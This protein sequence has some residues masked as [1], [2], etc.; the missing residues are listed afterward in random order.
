MAEDETPRAALEV[1]ADGVATIR[2]RDPDGVNSI[3]DR[4]AGS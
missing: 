1:G 3:D 2:P 4:M